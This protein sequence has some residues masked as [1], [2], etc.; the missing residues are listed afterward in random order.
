LNPS[1]I[2]FSDRKAKLASPAIIVCGGT[3]KTTIS[4][5]CESRTSRGIKPHVHAESGQVKA[6]FIQTVVLKT[7]KKIEK[8]EGA[9]YFKKPKRMPRFGTATRSYRIFEK[10][11]LPTDSAWL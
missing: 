7:M 2:L 9:F 5:H 1:E 4:M 11:A 6:H 3:G 10:P 8:E